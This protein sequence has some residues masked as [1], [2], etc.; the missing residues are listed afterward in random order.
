MIYSN[1]H[2]HTTLSDG[3]CTPREM[4]E[5]ALAR[6][7]RSLGF[8]DHG[9]TYIDKTMGMTVENMLNYNHTIN[10]LKAEYIGEIDIFRGLEN[11]LTQLHTPQAYDYTIGAVHYVPQGGKYYCVDHT[12]EVL[13]DAIATAFGGDGL[14]LT[15]GYFGEIARLAS[16]RSANICAHFDLVRLFNE[17]GR[18]FDEQSPVYQKAALDALEEVVRNGMLL[19]INTAII[20]K[21]RSADPYP[22]PFLLRRARELGARV[23]VSSDAHHADYLSYGFPEME[24]LLLAFGFAETWELTPRGFVPV[25][26]AAAQPVVQSAPQVAAQPVPQEAAPQ[27]A[28]PMQAEDDL[29]GGED[30][31]PPKASWWSKRAERRQARKAEKEAEYEEDS[32]YDDE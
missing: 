12:P 21:G 18:Y 20:A 11:D 31:A 28:A 13:Q 1:L 17:G 32:R 4:V 23:L 27:P 30:D 6:G 8:S 3:K 26:L 22:A 5:A 7:F 9:Y 2:T 19:E 14:A 16:L 15:K 29:G 25:P 24:E 10:A